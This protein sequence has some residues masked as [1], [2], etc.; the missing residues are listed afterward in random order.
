MLAGRIGRRR[1]DPISEV[2]SYPI[3]IFRVCVAVMLVQIFFFTQHLTMEQPCCRSDI[4]KTY[5]IRE[6]EKLTNQGNRECHINRVATE[7][8]DAVRYELVRMAG[9]DSDSKALPK[10]DDAPQQQQ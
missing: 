6:Y 5:P 3:A 7:G 8:E 2:A 9:I 4:D 1:D 10:G